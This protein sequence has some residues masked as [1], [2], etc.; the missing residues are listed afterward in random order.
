[1]AGIR[2]QYGRPAKTKV[3]AL[4]LKGRCC[5][6]AMGV[7]ASLNGLRMGLDRKSTR[8]NSSHA[9]ISYAVFCLKK[10]KTSLPPRHHELRARRHARYLPPRQFRTA[11]PVH[12]ISSITH[13]ARAVHP[14]RYYLLRSH[15]LTP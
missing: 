5:N 13:S 14:L 1:M 8:L 10:K 15:L 9:N 3:L 4:S 11:L 2:G 12:P 6:F 7:S